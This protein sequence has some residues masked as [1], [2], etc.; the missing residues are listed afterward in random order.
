M[1]LAIGNS[2]S[3]EF[4]AFNVVL[5][6]LK[7]KGQEAVLFKQDKCL[8]G[9]YLVFETIN[10]R[11]N[12]R[13]VIDGAD[14]DIEDF[15]A[16]WYMKPHLPIK[17]MQFEPAEYR[18]FIQ[19]QFRV[20]RTS[21]WSVFQHKKWI[22]DPWAIEKA[23]NKIYQLTMA[24]KARLAF[25][26]TLVTSDPVRVKAFYKK[27]GSNIIIKLLGASPREN[28]VLYTNVVTDEHLDNLDTVKMS[29]SIFQARIP[30]AYELRISIVGEEIFPVK[31][32]SQGD[33][34]TS[35]DWR[36]KPKLNDFDV[37]ME[38]TSLPKNIEES[39]KRFM[40]ILGLRFGCIDMIVTP[41]GDYVFLEI[42]PNGQW[43]FVQLHTEAE[44]SKALAGLLL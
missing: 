22:D 3:Y 28:K 18:Q 9:E 19:N 32:N 13:V 8:D 33:D 20:M 11:V 29:P 30:K 35:L 43:Y 10:G 2:G 36:R 34:L 24:R 41:S 1:I 14:Y 39:L 23:E 5:A 25:P 40:K 31:I 37:K 27:Y 12:Y 4:S 7:N 6:E 44:I 16:I 42:N 38:Q 17:L 26:D 21:L 15:S